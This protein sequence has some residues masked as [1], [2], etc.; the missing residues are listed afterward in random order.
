[1]TKF[2]LGAPCPTSAAVYSIVEAGFKNFF[3]GDQ[4]DSSGGRSEYSGACVC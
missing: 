2:N 4:S 1:M 3:G